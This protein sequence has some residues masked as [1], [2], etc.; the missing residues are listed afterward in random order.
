M[1][2]KVQP[3]CKAPEEPS[4]EVRAAICNVLGG[5]NSKN[6]KV[7]NGFGAFWTVQREIVSRL[8]FVQLWVLQKERDT[9]P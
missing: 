3:K 5:F 9:A 7:F 8:R 6:S 1:L 4:T 2:H